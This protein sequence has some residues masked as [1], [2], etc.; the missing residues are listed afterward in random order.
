V[1]LRQAILTAVVAALVLAPTNAASAPARVATVSPGACTSAF[2]SP[3]P[4]S[5]ANVGDTITFTA[6]ATTCTAP[7]FRFYLQKP[8]GAWA[9]ST[10]FG[11]STW[12]WTTTG[13]IGGVYGVG[14]WARQTGSTARYDAYWI[15]TYNLI[16]LPCAA[17]YVTTAAISPFPAGSS[18]QFT[19]ADTRC[20]TAKFRFWLLKPGGSWKLMRDY[21]S[22]T[23]TWNTTGYPAGIYQVG[24]WARRAGSLKAYDTY[25]I[26][27]YGLGY[28]GLCATNGGISSPDTPPVPPGSVLTFNA[29]YPFACAPNGPNVEFWLKPPGGVWKVVRAYQ[30]NS[31]LNL[32]TTGLPVGTYEIG[33]WISI[34]RSPYN[35]Y[36]IMT[37]QLGVYTCTA[38]TIGSDIPS[39]QSPGATITFSASLPN[40]NCLSPD[41]EFWLLPSPSTGWVVV[42]PYSATATYTLDTTGAP[43]GMI[44]VGVWAR[45][46]GSPNRYDTYATMTFWLGS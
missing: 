8:G 33:A 12:A 18:V 19:G 35:S 20:T 17:A 4:A 13:L 46:T 21:G 31:T 44:Q 24:V 41:L 9:A 23:W 36:A 45:Q 29:E 40:S 5:P 37:F 1:R 27:T 7:E 16:L 15:G 14:V 3:N 10:G 30:Q 42:Q 22:S 26:K 28:A 11:G 2:M 39:P 25:G 43:A 38:V 6:S 34:G 32:D